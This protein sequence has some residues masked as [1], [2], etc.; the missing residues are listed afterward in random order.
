MKRTSAHRT[1]RTNI[2]VAI[3]L[4]ILTALVMVANISC[5][6]QRNGCRAVRGMSG[7]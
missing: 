5:I 7:Y 2:H 6:P 1:H 4:I 3:I